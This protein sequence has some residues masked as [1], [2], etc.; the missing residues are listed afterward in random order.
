MQDGPESLRKSRQNLSVKLNAFADHYKVTLPAHRLVGD[1]LLDR[2]CQEA[3][4]KTISLIPLTSFKSKPAVEADL[5]PPHKN[6]DASSASS[7]EL[8]SQK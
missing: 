8:E 2:C 6:P 1:D 3:D 4:A 7:K 5:A